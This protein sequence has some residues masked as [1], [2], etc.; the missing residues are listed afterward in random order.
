M[1]PAR[2][3]D[4][5]SEFRRVHPSSGPPEVERRGRDPVRQPRPGARRFPSSH[6]RGFSREPPPTRQ[7]ADDPAVAA[8][9]TLEIRGLAGSN[10]EL[11]AVEA[12]ADDRELFAKYTEADWPVVDV[13][14]RT[15]RGRDHIIYVEFRTH[16][17]A[18]NLFQVLAAYMR[19]VVDN[20]FIAWT[21]TKPVPMI[22]IA[23][24]DGFVPDI[25]RTTFDFRV[26]SKLVVPT[27]STSPTRRSRLDSKP[28]PPK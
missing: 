11:Q 20:S 3:P 18:A 12:W 23:D 10:L 5:E 14:A 15:I 17:H 13:R 24:A 9:T 6:E 19:T 21:S 7:N 2:R 16:Q 28:P 27:S 25:L 8:S 26:D 22:R 4:P 1:E